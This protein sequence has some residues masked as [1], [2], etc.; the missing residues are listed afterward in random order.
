M[1]L[2]AV[3]K[4]FCSCCFAVVIAGKVM[5]AADALIMMKEK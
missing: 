2:E 3:Q 1:L 5:V 4:K